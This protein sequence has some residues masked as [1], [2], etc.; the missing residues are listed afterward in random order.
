MFS[1]CTSAPVEGGLG[2]LCVMF[3]PLAWTVASCSCVEL[4]HWLMVAGPVVCNVL[5]TSLDCSLILAVLLQHWL[6]GGLGQLCVMFFPL[7]WTA[8]S[9]LCVVLQRWLMVARASFV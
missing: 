6:T 4:Q 2:Q 5:S 7:A 9:C 1:C 8:S 3:P